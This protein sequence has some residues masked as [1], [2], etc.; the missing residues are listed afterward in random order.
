MIETREQ[1][2]DTSEFQRAWLKTCEQFGFLVEPETLKALASEGFKQFGR[3][4]L[5]PFVST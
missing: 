3:G 1:L 2:I 5:C 4:V